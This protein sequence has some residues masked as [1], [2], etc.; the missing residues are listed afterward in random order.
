[1]SVGQYV[2]VYVMRVMRVMCA[3]VYVYKCVCVYA[4]L[5]AGVY[6]CLR[7]VCVCVFACLCVCV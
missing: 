3:F 4:C 7:V 1:M 5:C 6:V 2:C